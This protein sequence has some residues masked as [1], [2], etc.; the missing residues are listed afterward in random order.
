MNKIFTI[1]KLAQ[2]FYDTYN[3]YDYPEIEH[4]ISRPYIVIIAKIDDYVFALPFR[5]NIKHYSYKF[6]NTTR[7]TNSSIGIDFTK[8]VL[9]KDESYIG[10]ETTID[11]KEYVELMNKYYFILIKFKA[12]LKGYIKFLGSKSNE[13]LT[14]KY[15][16]C[17][18][19]YF[20]KEIIS[21]KF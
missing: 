15:K 12:Y 21:I 7:N 3:E 10:S 13:C 4:K 14:N 17:T 2:K 18:L 8:A 1:N 9:I 11:K 6:K 16:Y 19:K 20:E 5:T